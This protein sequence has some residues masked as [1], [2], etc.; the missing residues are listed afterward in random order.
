MNDSTA[1]PEMPAEPVIASIPRRLGAGLI[2]FVIFMALGFL[3][4]IAYLASGLTENQWMLSEIGGLWLILDY[5][6]QSVLRVW[7]PR[8]TLGDLACGISIADWDGGR[9]GLGL[10][11]AR[12][13]VRGLPWVLFYAINALVQSRM[14]DS[15][16]LGFSIMAAPLISVLAV[17][18]VPFAKRRLAVYD[19]LTKTLVVRRAKKVKPH[20]NRFESAEAA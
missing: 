12:Y 20:S 4:L 6:Y 14:H 18:T 3:S 19:M 8:G 1:P 9:P 16:V 5:L 13:L 2:D 7:W 10:I 11:S 17:V 15:E